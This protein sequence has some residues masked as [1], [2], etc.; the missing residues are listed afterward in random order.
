MR[1]AGLAGYL[2]AIT[3]VTCAVLYALISA[4]ASPAVSVI[5]MLLLAL[6]AL[7][8]ASEAALSLVNFSVTRLLDAS[9]LPGLILR[10]GVPEHMRTLVA[11]P[12]LLTSRDDT[13]EMIE[14]LEVHYLSNSEG[15]LYFALVTD[16][17]DSREEE[18][19]AADA[20]LLDDA[21]AGISALN[22]R[23]DGN[24][25]LLLHRSR[26]WNA[27]QGRW[28]G[29]E[30]KR[31]KLH[32]LNRLLMGADDTSFSVIS[33][34][35][36]KAVRYVL[37]LDAD[38]KLPRDAARR[39]VGKIAHPLNQPRFDAAAGRVTEGYAVLQP[40]VTPSLPTGHNGSLFQ[41]IFSTPRGT[42]PYV[43]AVSD[44]YQDL[45]GEGS[46]A[47]KGIYDIAA[48]E[49]ALS[50][51]IPEN[52]MLSHDLFEGIFA[53]SALVTDV[54]VVEEY[55][56]RYT[57]A[58]SRQHRWTRGDWQLLPWLTGAGSGLPALGR[59]KM[60]DNLRR[61]ALPIATLVCLFSGWAFLPPWNA[62]LWTLGIALLGVIPPLLP[63]LSG[64]MPRERR[65][66]F[67]SRAK[68][69]LGDIGHSL[70]FSAANL[71]FLAHQAGLM[72][73]AIVRTLHRLRVSRKNLLEWTTAAQ[74][75][76]SPTPGIGAHYSLMAASAAAGIAALALAFARFDTLSI[77]I[78]A[79]AAAW[80]AAPAAAFWASRVPKLADTQK[81][82]A[83]DIRALRLTARRTW[84]FFEAFVTEPDSMLPPDNFQEDPAPRI[85]H[86]TSPTN[87]G[88]YLLSV[89]SAK[90]FGWLGLSD[91]AAKLEA[92]LATVR[93]MEKYRG[94]LY[95]WY[96]TQTLRPLEPKYVSSVDSG[97]LAG[98]LIA[99]ANCCNVWI[100]EPAVDLIRLDGLSDVAEI[101]AQECAALPGERRRLRPLRRQLET[102][103]AAFQRSLLKARTA[104]EM[105]SV[106]LIELAVQA[107]SIHASAEELDAGPE[108]ASAG[109]LLHWAGILR[110]TIESQFKDASLGHALAQA[111][112]QRL[113]E[114]EA[115]ARAMALGMEFGFLLD[116]QRLLLAIGF[117][118]P[119][120]MRDES[121]YDMLASEAR[122]GSFFAIAKGDLRTRHWF[123][124][125]RSVTAVRGGAA[126]IS[127]SGSMFEYLMPSLVMRAPSGGLLGSD[128]Q[129][130]GA[131]ADRL[132]QCARRSLGNLRV[133]LQRARH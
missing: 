106:R 132:R 129:A 112:K 119:E 35:V 45:F 36:P 87:I 28:M 78:A 121:C 9:I 76:S 75:A 116:P 42:D 130:R 53:R 109:Q 39:L 92:T 6:A 73:D 123:R 15:E 98:H 100:T 44:V 31:G 69:V 133:R 11:V 29:W 22:R 128:H 51:R 103:I 50:G 33:G 52:A 108:P 68:A 99:L 57:V 47:G 54:E 122:L 95:N 65:H 83:E 120:E 115:D 63:A 84:R 131:Q 88:L 21:L 3:L 91:A 72:A 19:S 124:Q 102:Q 117:R 17:A 24:R 60:I 26:K 4:A 27:Q 79:F 48:F 71:I 25:F 12:I 77:L 20:Q 93:H 81:V 67:E 74:A 5:F 58:A 114:I 34:E 59:W 107:A 13:E 61:S 16:W 46:F 43:F 96:D 62:A 104:P 90:E 40:R 1:A 113:K 126:L 66:T 7:L 56:E 2:G 82:S 110:E 23:Y 80:L 37:T 101:L 14:R 89:A 8:P 86:R 32:E 55:P 118:V 85:A 127:W 105:I 10:D 18:T 30:R 97:N 125:G 64:A 38:T 111:L 41:R 70:A 49:A 94:H